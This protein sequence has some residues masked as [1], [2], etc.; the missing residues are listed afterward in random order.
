MAEVGA[1]FD[2]FAQGGG[3][4]EE[5]DV[6]ITS[7]RF[8]TWDYR[9]KSNPVLGLNL[10]MTDAD[11]QEHDEW[12]SA[13]DL[14]FFVPSADGK[15]AVPVGTATKLNGSTNAA[16]FIISLLNADTR[17]EFAAKVRSTDDISVLD[18]LKVHVSRKAA[19]KRSGIVIQPGQENKQQTQLV[20]D[21]V[22]A[23]PGE[24]GSAPATKAAAPA[25][26]SA[27][28]PANALADTARATL[29]SIVGAAG[30]SIKK[31]QLASKV[32]AE[33][34]DAVPATRN[35]VLGMIV[36][37]DFLNSVAEVGLAY[38]AATGTISFA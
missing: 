3:G 20:V 4:I 36:R 38:D 18:G 21:K 2:E 1:M 9:G 5:G 29:L 7:A 30:G 28:A 6:T 32:L 26:A 31:T 17:G 23:Y 13:G 14:K 8:G 27:A 16:A 34:K 22:I 19:P 12:L 10:K 35:G 25:A 37:D 15:K 33:M 11:G 24:A